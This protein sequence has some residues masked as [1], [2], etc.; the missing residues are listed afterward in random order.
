MTDPRES[1][2]QQRALQGLVRF[3]IDLKDKDHSKLEK[4]LAPDFA[5]LDEGREPD[6]TMGLALSEGGLAILA[7]GIVRLVRS[8][9]PRNQCHTSEDQPRSRRDTGRIPL[10]NSMFGGEGGPNIGRTSAP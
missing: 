10:L 1:V 9:S 6:L 8:R 5:I 4:S 3:G 7:F 2:L